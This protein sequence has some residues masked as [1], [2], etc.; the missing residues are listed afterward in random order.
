MSL[1][2]SEKIIGV[3]WP[4]QRFLRG[5]NPGPIPCS[6]SPHLPSSKHPPD[7]LGL[8]CPPGP[9]H[10]ASTPVTLL[11]PF[12]TSAPSGLRPPAP[13]RHLSHSSTALHINQFS[14]FPPQII[15]AVQVLC[16]C[17]LAA[18]LFLCVIS[19]FLSSS[20]SSFVCL[21]GKSLFGSNQVLFE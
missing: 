10:L 2:R 13:H 8:C 15:I 11:W 12:P 7:A 9:P 6:P 5:G 1:V 18:S 20:S 19:S 3:L 4:G 16:A 14:S 21:W 17:R